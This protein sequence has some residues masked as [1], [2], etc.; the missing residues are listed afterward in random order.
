MR[1]PSQISPEQLD[2]GVKRFSIGIGISI[3]EE[4]ED[5]LQMILNTMSS[6]IKLFDLIGFRIFNP[7]Q[8]LF[9]SH[10]F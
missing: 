3:I 4:V 2:F 10:R 5:V 7:V 8:K 1:H 6:C 9:F